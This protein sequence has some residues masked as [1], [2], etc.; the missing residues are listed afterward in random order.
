MLFQHICE[1]AEDDCEASIFSLR[2][3]P[4]MTEEVS[5]MRCQN[6]LFPKMGSTCVCTTL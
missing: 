6:M 3:V 2:L 1:Q 4:S 5:L